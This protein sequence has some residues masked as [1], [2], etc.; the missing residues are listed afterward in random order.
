MQNGIDGDCCDIDQSRGE[1][2]RPVGPH[3]DRSARRPRRRRRPRCGAI[4]P[5]H[6]LV[7]RP[8]LVVVRRPLHARDADRRQPRAVLVRRAAVGDRHERRGAATSQSCRATATSCSTTSTASRCGP[9]HRRPRRRALAVQDDGNRSCTP[10]AS[11]CGRRTPTA[12][13]PRR[14]RAARSSP[15]RARAGRVGVVVRRR[16]RAGDAG[17]R[18]PGALSRRHGALWSIAHGRHRRPPRRDAGR[19]Q[20]RRLRR[21]GALGRAAPTATAAR[22]S[23]CRTTATSSIYAGATPIW[24]TGTNGQ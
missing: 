15:A 7:A 2:L 8:E 20:P 19:R 13:R 23:R 17:R 3:R 1:R 14:R 4:E 10:A 22:G 16:A 6:G 24:A 12:C 18:Q 5:G 9:G 21:R 11:R